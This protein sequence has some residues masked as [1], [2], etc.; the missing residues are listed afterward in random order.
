MAKSESA[1]RP[2]PAPGFLN[3]N[4]Q[5]AQIRFNPYDQNE[6]FCQYFFEF[7]IG[8]GVCW[9]LDLDSQARRDHEQVGG[10]CPW[11]RP[12]QESLLPD[13]GR[14]RLL[15]LCLELWVLLQAQDHAEEGAYYP[16]HVTPSQ[17]EQCD[18]MAVLLAYP[19]RAGEPIWG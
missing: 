17:P 4:L 14:N 6:V 7:P 15:G 2:I 12:R 16:G 11:L 18:H 19:D 8:R 13:A 5:T 9:L 3:S 10:R 1:N